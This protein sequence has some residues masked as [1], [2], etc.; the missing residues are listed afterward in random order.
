MGARILATQI[1][2]TPFRADGVTCNGH[3]LDQRKR[4]TLENGAILERTGLA[5]ISIADEVTRRGRLLG[6]ALPFDAGRECRTAAPH[7]SGILD[8]ADDF[9]GLHFERPSQPGVTILF[10]I[11]VDAFRIDLADALEQHQAFLT[12]L[13]YGHDRRSLGRECRWAIVQCEGDLFDSG[14]S[15]QILVRRIASLHRHRGRGAL[16]YTQTGTVLPAIR[17]SGRA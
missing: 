2:I 7:Q 13:R 1:D 14:R 6:G 5:L 15:D 8:L 11:V 17:S 3:R 10:D 16:A 12:S 9:P 4:V